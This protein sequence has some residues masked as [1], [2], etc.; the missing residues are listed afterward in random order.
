MSGPP[1]KRSSERRRRNAPKIPLDKVT[2]LPEGSLP[3][4]IKEPIPD[5]YMEPNPDW[6][7]IV[8]RLFESFARSGQAIFWEPS[9]W[10]VA[11]FA[12][13]SMSRDLG[14]QFVGIS[15]TTGEVMR[16]RIP[17]KGT[18]LAAY[19]KVFSQLM[20]TESERRRFSMEIER[21]QFTDQKPASVS[22]IDTRRQGR[23]G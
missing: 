23:V 10:A 14:P 2:E 17:L 4:K 7:P 20:V 15:E 6:D 19:L 1:P 16:E 18:S 13:E 8:I 9:D 12:C 22:D 5:S 11:H 21:R 3:A